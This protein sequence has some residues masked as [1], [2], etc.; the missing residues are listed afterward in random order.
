MNDRLLKFL[1]FNQYLRD[2]IDVF[3]EYFIRFY[4]EFYK[5]DIREEIEEKFH[6]CLFIGYQ[7]PT[8]LEL[9][10]KKIAKNK[11]NELMDSLLK[12]NLLSLTKNDLFSTYDFTHSNLH[13]IHKYLE[14]YKLY[15]LGE[16]G[17]KKKFYQEKYSLIHKCLPD[18]TFD[19]FMDIVEKKEIPNKYVPL[20]LWL[21]NNFNYVF[22]SN[23]ILK[24][25]L[26][27]FQASLSLLSKIDSSINQDNFNEKLQDSKFLDLN[28]LMERYTNALDEF[29]L[30]MSKFQSYMDYV[31][32]T[33][34]LDHELQNKYYVKFIKENLDL[35][36]VD[37]REG[38]EELFENPRNSYYKLNSCIKIIFGYFLLN[39]I[40]LFAFSRENEKMLNNP[41]TTPWLIN[42]TKNKRISYF[43]ANG[44]DFGDVYENYL[45][46]E[47]V[48]KIWPSYE[49]IEQLQNS[50]D[51]ILNQYHNEYF[52]SLPENKRIRQEIKE[53]NFLD[54]SD[55]F[56]ARLYQESGT[57][58][59]PNITL[60]SIGYNLSSLMIIKGN[61]TSNFNDHNIVHELNHLFE[62]F[63]N[64]VNDGKYRVVCGWDRLEGV[65]ETS[66]NTFKTEDISDEKR[67]YELFNEII[68]ELITQ[69]ICQMMH[70]D[71]IFVFDDPKN[72]L[73][74]NVTDY[75]SS[76]FLVKEFF[77]QNKDI[78]IRSRKDGNIGVIFDAIGK[79]NFDA[80]N[81]LFEIY[82][83]NFS[84]VKIYTLLDSLSKGEDTPATRV[85]YD[86]IDRKN[87][88]LT[89]IDAYKASMESQKISNSV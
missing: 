36:P 75:E 63:L 23:N 32:D 56:N 53:R 40:P 45:D 43:K 59:N 13:P 78:I 10:L 33:E 60:T 71:G 25:Y 84:G 16:D 68:N 48:K 4:S 2:H 70:N 14:F 46:K 61:Y 20:S 82:Y 7:S 66:K 19:D 1:D 34:K 83:K 18:L 38:L 49:K 39:N 67:P 55:S 21:E 77:E 62:L 41:D 69:D 54:N 88:I 24:E 9:L 37:K 72:S 57:F 47:E 42:E 79:E 6:R 3:K 12:S 44:I 81:S 11:S 22:D 27:A 87:Q 86:L 65:I 51:E 52:N 29:S 28:Q 30:Y 74:K 85:Y 5:E 89:N 50:Y 31:H 64:S 17:R 80:L 35:I 15:Q 73:Y 8:E 26:N 58:I 76:L